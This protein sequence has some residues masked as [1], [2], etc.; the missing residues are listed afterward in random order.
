MRTKIKEK[1]TQVTAAVIAVMFFYAI[2]VKMSDYQ[3]AFWDM[4]NQVFSENVAAILTWL[5]PVIEFL[6]IILLLYK[7]QTVVGLWGA[8]LLLTTFSLY[9]VLAKY[10]FFDRTPCSCGG[11]L[12]SGSTYNGQLWFNLAFIILA[13]TALVLHYNLLPKGKKQL[14][15]LTG[16]YQT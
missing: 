8:L 16:Q 14:K 15:D 5:I 6:L 10:N 7:P 2:V 11:I 4:H 13:I 1:L 3:Q 12:G 9:I